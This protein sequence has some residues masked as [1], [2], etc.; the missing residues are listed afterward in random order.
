MYDERAL[1]IITVMLGSMR[2]LP[3]EK[4]RKTLPE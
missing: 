2:S 4:I 1:H 3:V